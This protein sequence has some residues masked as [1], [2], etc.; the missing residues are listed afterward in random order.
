[1]DRRTFLE[2]AAVSVGAGILGKFEFS[3]ENPELI[4][5]GK[6]WRATVLR[7]D[8]PNGNNHVYSKALLK[9]IVADCKE[10]VSQRG[11]VGQLGMS[12]KS[13]VEFSKASHVITDV[14]LENDYLKI[15]LETMNTPNG[16]T[17]R[18]LLETPNVVAFRTCGVG[19]SEQKGDNIVIG[20]EYKLVSVHAVPAQK[21]AKL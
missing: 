18:N 15:D 17:L 5:I 19:S 2:I 1:M 8:H 7:A 6:K 9:K 4:Q 3:P 16:K 10:P 20:E 14:F 13:Y 12:E 11:L 21:A